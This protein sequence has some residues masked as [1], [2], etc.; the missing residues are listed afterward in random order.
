MTIIRHQEDLNQTLSFR[1]LSTGL[2]WSSSSW[3]SSKLPSMCAKLYL[4]F[5]FSE[6]WHLDCSLSSGAMLPLS[7]RRVHFFRPRQMLFALCRVWNGS[8]NM[9]WRSGPSW[10]TCRISFWTWPKARC[11]QC[12]P[13]CW[14]S[15]R[16]L[17]RSLDTRILIFVKSLCSLYWNSRGTN[18][19]ILEISEESTF[20]WVRSRA[21]QSIL[22]IGS[23]R[24]Y[25]PQLLLFTC[26]RPATPPT[27]L[28]PHSGFRGSIEF[29]SMKLLPSYLSQPCTSLFPGPE[30]LW[31]AQDAAVFT[32]G[33]HLPTSSD[34][35]WSFARGRRQPRS[36]RR[37][38]GRNGFKWN[39]HSGHPCTTPPDSA[40]YVFRLVL[41]FDAFS[42]SCLR[43]LLILSPD[44]PIVECFDLEV[45]ANRA[46][47]V[48][49]P[50]LMA[51]ERLSVPMAK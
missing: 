4:F 18:P 46:S 21:M 36:W 33:H 8:F 26:V 1:A 32:A 29:S 17:K 50:I 41:Q 23:E 39:A 24:G 48:C 11:P 28:R 35:V 42:P 31:S 5:F 37:W 27:V 25:A 22:Q 49:E 45:P 30:P 3:T 14:P 15:G 9:A 47:S 16:R 12:K 38:C 19:Q 40:Q 51:M 13:L 7:R 2:M 44:G 20:W 43:L 10:P 34:W 6:N